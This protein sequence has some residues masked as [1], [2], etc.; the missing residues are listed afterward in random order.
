MYLCERDVFVLNCVL[1]ACFRTMRTF[2]LLLCV[3]L[4]LAAPKKVPHKAAVHKTAA[5]HEQVAKPVNEPAVKAV[6]QQSADNSTWEQPEYCGTNDC[7]IFTTLQSN[8]EEVGV[9]G[10]MRKCTEQC[11]RGGC[12]GHSIRLLPFV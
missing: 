12:G 6:K 5:V 10:V 4:A 3:G 1:C 8:V 9:A 11:R 2:T 7:P